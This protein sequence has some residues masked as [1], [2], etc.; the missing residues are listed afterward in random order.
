MKEDNF[1][2][3][4][5]FLA[6][7]IVMMISFALGAWLWTYSINTWLVYAGKVTCVKWWQGG[8]IGFCP[9]IGK[10][11]IPVAVVTWIL[12]MVL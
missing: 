11:C 4:A 9:F 10:L 8:L 2:T 6:F 5:R 12:M 7:L 3:T 1:H